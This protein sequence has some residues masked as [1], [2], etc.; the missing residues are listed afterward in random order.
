MVLRDRIVIAAEMTELPT[1]E[2]ASKKT[3]SAEPGTVSLFAPPEVS[4]QF[5]L[6][7]A[8]QLVEEPPPTQNLSAIVV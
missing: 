4:D 2:L 1:P 3:S 8:F 5:V 6:P 7:V